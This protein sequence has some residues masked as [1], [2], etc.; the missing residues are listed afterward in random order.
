MDVGYLELRD[1]CNTSL[2]FLTLRDRAFRVERLETNV[3]RDINCLNYNE[4]KGEVA[5]SLPIYA[6]A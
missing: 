3:Y 4:P 6:M 5:H 2:M 1:R